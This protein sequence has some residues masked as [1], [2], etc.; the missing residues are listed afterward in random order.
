MAPKAISSMVINKNYDF[1][2]NQSLISYSVGK[3]FYN[4]AIADN[5]FVR[6]SVWLIGEGDEHGKYNC[7]LQTNNGMSIPNILAT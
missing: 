2:G 3:M 1:H 5:V 6:L 7:V 4:C